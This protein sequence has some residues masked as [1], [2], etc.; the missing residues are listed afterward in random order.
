MF[1]EIC[2]RVDG[3]KNQLQVHSCIWML[4]EYFWVMFCYFCEY[5]TTCCSDLLILVH[6]YSN[7]RLNLK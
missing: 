3:V 7:Q 2:F 6:Q 4:V 1:T 5:S